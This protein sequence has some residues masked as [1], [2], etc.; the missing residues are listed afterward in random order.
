MKAQGLSIVIAIGGTGGNGRQNTGAE[1]W[2]E[3]YTVCSL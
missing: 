1:S 3:V 2:L